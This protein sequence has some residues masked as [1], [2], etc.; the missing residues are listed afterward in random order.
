MNLSEMRRLRKVKGVAHTGGANK[1]EGTVRAM[2]GE[3]GFLSHFPAIVEMTRRIGFV[4]KTP[5][6]DRAILVS[7]AYLRAKGIPVFVNDFLPYT[8]KKKRELLSLLRRNREVHEAFKLDAEQDMRYVLSSFDRINE[9]LRRTPEYRRELHASGRQVVEKLH[10][11]GYFRK[12]RIVDV[13]FII[14]LSNLDSSAICKAM[15]ASGICKLGCKKSTIDNKIADLRA[16]LFSLE[17]G[18]GPIPSE[19][20]AKKDEFYRDRRQSKL[21]RIERGALK[22]AACAGVQADLLGG[23][24]SPLPLTHEDILIGDLLKH[25]FSKEDVYNLTK[26][27][28]EYHISFLRGW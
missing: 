6:M 20:V 8:G 4:T 24:G 11:E 12:E 18:P 1:V 14:L 26:Q 9:I 3:I 21:M 25:G 27:G 22:Y 16:R 7:Y 5:Q 15:R 17:G 2:L 19:A 28:M 23:E 10:G 13:A